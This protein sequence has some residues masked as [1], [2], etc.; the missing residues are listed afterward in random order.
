MGGIGSGHW[1]R[2][3]RKTTC[4]ECRRIDIRYLKK[5]GW[6]I[7]GYR[8]WLSWSR[9]GESSGYIQFRVEDYRIILAYR[10]RWCEGE[11]W[12]DIEESVWLDRT[13]CHYGGYRNWFQC[14]RCGER[15]ALLYG[16][17]IR[18]LCRHCYG[19]AYASQQENYYDRMLRKARNYREKL[20]ASGDLSEPILFK[21]KGMRQKT[22]D[23]LVREAERV[24]IKA[25]RALALWFMRRGIG[26]GT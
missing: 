8:G 26:M 18:F 16:A 23:R 21:P 15:V 11:E 6:L 2:W 10:H 3:D 9:G 24:E 22:F 12:Q 19:L 5:R 1:Y 13:P 14:P 25:D 20:G 7:P 4:E 17:G